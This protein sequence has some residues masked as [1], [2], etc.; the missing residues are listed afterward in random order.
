MRVLVMGPEEK[1][2]LSKLKENAIKNI[3]SFDDLLDMKNEQAP[4]PG[5]IDGFSCIIPDGFRVVY[6]I[7]HHPKTDGS[8]FT[9]IRHASIS[10]HEEGKLPNP[11][12]CEMIIAEL[13]FT[14]PLENCLI[15]V[16][17]GYAINVMEE[18]K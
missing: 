6:S 3:F 17:G 5:D 2:K 12:A 8:G 7:E 10:V 14:N 4:I 18:Y 1:D 9:P 13:G 11:H 16:E 15:D